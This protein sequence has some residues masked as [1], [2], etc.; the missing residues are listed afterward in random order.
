MFFVV[1]NHTMMTEKQVDQFGLYGCASRAMIAF[2]GL[3]NIRFSEAE[4]CERFE[5]FFPSKSHCYGLLPLSSMFL[6]ARELGLCNYMDAC[7]D[8][9]HVKRLCDGPEKG[10]PTGVLLLT[11]REIKDGI[12]QVY[13]HCR[14]VV[15]YKDS[16]W[17]VWARDEDGNEGSFRMADSDLDQ[18]L[19][20]L[21]IFY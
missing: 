18:L 13:H 8:R 3:H 1:H 5:S 9:D 11:H 7:S 15:D 16:S 6:I 12:L 21:V 4:F 14:C 10:R 19:A 2:A 20:Q 17:F